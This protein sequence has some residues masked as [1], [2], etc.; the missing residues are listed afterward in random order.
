MRG[1]TVLDVASVLTG[2]PAATPSREVLVEEAVDRASLLA[3]RQMRRETFVAEQRLLAA[4]DQVASAD[5]GVI[6]RALVLTADPAAVALPPDPVPVV[7]P[8]LTGACGAGVG[9][10]TG[11]E[12]DGTVAIPLA[13]DAGAGAVCDETDATGAAAGGAGW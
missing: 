8:A 11:T 12:A 3:Y 5:R 1:T 4:V 9:A 10:A 6:V 7:L 2:H 13:D